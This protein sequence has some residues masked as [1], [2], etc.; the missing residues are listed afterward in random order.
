MSWDVYT[1]TRPV[2]RKEY[3]CDACE[4][5]SSFGLME[6]D[7]NPDEWDAIEEARSEGSKILPGTKYI[8]CKGIYEG[9]PC[10]FRARADIDK[11]C[12]DND[13]YDL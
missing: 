5:I 7:L 10:T 1:V 4:L 13:F 2:A 12:T 3:D 11:I 6:G 9:M 8:K